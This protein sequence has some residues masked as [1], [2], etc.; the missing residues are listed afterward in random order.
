MEV[1]FVPSR[2]WIHFPG[3]FAD[4]FGGHYPRE[5]STPIGQIPEKFREKDPA[6]LH[7]PY[8][9]MIGDKFLIQFGPRV[10]SL[11]TKQNTYPGWGEFWPEMEKI[12]QGVKDLKIVKEATRV[13]LRYT[14]YFHTDVFQQ[15]TLSLGVNGQEIV[16]PETGISTVFQQGR[17][18]HFVQINNSSVIMA[19][20]QQT[21]LGSILDIDTS[22]ETRVDDIFAGAKSLFD[23]AH[24][25]EKKVFFGLLKSSFV[26]TL[27]PQYTNDSHVFTH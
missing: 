6:L 22:L 5:E 3:L 10:I 9:K 20:N 8:H 21:Q 1:R 24:L 18:R 16:L 14:N 7:S 23:E 4:K 25:L 17:F 27:K 15:L 26:N 19:A 2:P 11:V 13:G 12:L